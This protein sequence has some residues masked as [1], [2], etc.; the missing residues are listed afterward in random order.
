MYDR[1]Q[2]DLSESLFN[3]VFS[4][5]YRIAEQEQAAIWKAAKRKSD[6]W[7]GEAQ[8]NLTAFCKGKLSL[9]HALDFIN[10]NDAQLRDFW[11]GLEP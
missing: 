11:K 4:D 8:E 2:R 7:I 9:G 5:L 3:S 6:Y 10:S 1:H